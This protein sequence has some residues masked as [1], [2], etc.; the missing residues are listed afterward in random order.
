MHAMEVSCTSR[1]ENRTYGKWPWVLYVTSLKYHPKEQDTQRVSHAPHGRDSGSSSVQHRRR[2][3]RK[4]FFWSNTFRR[5]QSHD[6]SKIYRFS[7]GIETFTQGLI[8]NFR[9]VKILWKAR[10]LWRLQPLKRGLRKLRILRNVEKI[11]NIP[12]A[13]LP[14]SKVLD[15]SQGIPPKH[16]HFFWRLQPCII[17]RYL[18]IF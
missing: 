3:W 13:S 4:L 8:R 11:L 17:S 2:S 15:F 12:K 1:K 16:T 7:W 14:F 6:F 5:L 9:S 10:L 18:R